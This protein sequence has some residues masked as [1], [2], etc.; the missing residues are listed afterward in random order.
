MKKR[1]LL[2]LMLLAFAFMVGAGSAMADGEVWI[3]T[4]PADLKSGD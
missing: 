4:L 1:H 3:K 2:K